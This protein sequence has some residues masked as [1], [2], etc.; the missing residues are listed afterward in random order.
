MALRRRKQQRT[1]T[2]ADLLVVALGNPGDQYVGTRHNIGVEVIDVLAQRW[3]G[4]FRKSKEAALTC[5]VRIG[6]S[7]VALAFPQTYMNRS[8]ESVRPLV[9][10][11]GIEDLEKL[12]VVHDEL[13]LPPGRIRVK[14][15]G[16]LAGHNGLKSI[17]DHLRTQDFLRVRVGVGRPSHPN[18]A[19]YVLKRPGKA[20]R[21]VLDEAVD[22]AADAVEMILS[23]GYEAAMMH[24]NG[25]HVDG[26]AGE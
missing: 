10:R 5:E 8:G 1:G 9:R 17:R 14:N 21:P 25:T 26:A 24:F 11:H 19:D 12:I 16:G 4:S 3:H 23:Q 2:S 20:D 18:V 15:G 22:R 6:E 7:R 13:D